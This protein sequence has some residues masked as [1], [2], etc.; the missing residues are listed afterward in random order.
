MMHF[1]HQ[2]Q[3]QKK[4]KHHLL[5]LLGG[6]F[7]SFISAAALAEIKNFNPENYTKSQPKPLSNSLD[8]Y[9]QKKEKLTQKL[10]IDLKQALENNEKN[11]QLDSA[12]S[13]EQANAFSIADIRAKA[14]KNNLSLEVARIDP[15]I[16]GA[17]L[18]RE[19]AK[20]D[21]IIFAYAKKTSR[22]LPKMSGD[23][24]VFSSNEPLL[25]NREA[26]INTLDQNL[27]SVDIAAGVRVPL[28][29]GGTV[30]LSSPLESK[31][32]AGPFSSEEYRSA[33]RFSISQPLLR[34][35]GKDINEASIRIAE[36]DRQSVQLTTKLQAI[37]VIAMTDK[38]YWALYEAWALL[39][40][41]KQ[42]YQLA[43]Q[44]LNMVKRRVEEGLTAAIEL[45]RAEIGVADR[46]EA[47]IIAETNLKLAQRQ[48][49]F[50]MNDMENEG[51]QP[52]LINPIT[53]PFLV[54]YEFDRDKLLNDAMSG[55]LELLDLE[56]K[57][58]A[59][60]V[61]IQYLE[62]QT[63]PLFSLDYQYGALSPTANQFGR[64]Y[65]NM[66]SGQYN[67]WSI[68]LTFEMPFTN[69]ANKARL[70]Q[71]VQQRNKRLATKQLQ[72]LTVKKEIYDAL[73]QIENNWQ[74]I[75]AARQQVVI[76][77]MNYQAEL[78]QFNEG[79]R[80]MTEVLETL[81]RLGEAQIKEVRAISDY[82][83]SI[84]DSAYATGT[85]LGYSNLELN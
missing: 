54:Y 39:D 43:I 62:N 10:R 55:R 59:D 33:L 12:F 65:Q 23:N 27:D 18:R 78:K 56:V 52:N 7:L 36:Y 8:E 81:T 32:N 46:M 85:V 38:S 5:G 9:Q 58:A 79:L 49:R 60:A 66:L 76:A 28:R 77:G 61:N 37:R 20:F 3:Q 84:I 75:L 26:K 14:L 48:L 40:V 17:A 68:G 71:A 51:Q 42:Q 30:I 15:A 72:T 70:D 50:F 2:S 11:T 6:L 44:N 53:E 73:D 24:V 47:L 25:D 80:T 64:S 74:R 31:K 35:A 34:N 13:K 4:L 57:L 45:N 22:D 21:N 19:Q 69:E 41:R 1:S 16:A 83:A 63:L 82:Q 67:D 29:T